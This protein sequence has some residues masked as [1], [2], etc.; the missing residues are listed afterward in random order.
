[1]GH[2]PKGLLIDCTLLKKG[3]ER[4]SIRVIRGACRE[5]GSSPRGERRAQV[6][7]MRQ[8]HSCFLFEDSSEMNLSGDLLLIIKP[9]RG[10]AQKGRQS[11][12][13]P[14]LFWT[15]FEEWVKEAAAKL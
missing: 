2:G 14:L 10:I 15:L 1:M 12:S 4:G 5:R 3:K 6:P 11:C 13:C 9:R 7:G 8:Q